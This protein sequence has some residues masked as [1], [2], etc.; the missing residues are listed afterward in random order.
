[1][2][3]V[4]NENVPYT[5]FSPTRSGRG[6][7][8]KWFALY[9]GIPRWTISHK[10]RNCGKPLGIP[11]EHTAN[12]VCNQSCQIRCLRASSSSAS[13]GS[14][15]RE[16]TRIASEYAHILDDDDG[17][18]YLGTAGRPNPPDRRRWTWEA[19]GWTPTYEGLRFL[20]QRTWEC[21][22]SR[23]QSNRSYSRTASSKRILA[24]ATRTHAAASRHCRGLVP[25]SKFYATRARL[26]ERLL[27]PDLGHVL[28]VTAKL[29]LRCSE[30]LE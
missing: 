25:G 13:R 1:M 22:M 29:T 27:A 10:R 15:K 30:R 14:M 21:E 26:G 4:K 12:K 17:Y 23:S 20:T 6:G 28:G 16:D 11:L 9:S 2:N 18:Y 19:D 8:N 24:C 5:L 7:Q 3:C